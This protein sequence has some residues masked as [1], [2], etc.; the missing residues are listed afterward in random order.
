[1]CG[2]A[3]ARSG[4]RDRSPAKTAGF[5]TPLPLKPKPIVMP[6]P[7]TQKHETNLRIKYLAF[8][9]EKWLFS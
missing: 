2:R 6:I 7:D 8:C 3:K 9:P 4:P 5:L 1:M